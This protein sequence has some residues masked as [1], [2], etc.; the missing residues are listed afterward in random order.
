[1]T[2]VSAAS[3]LFLLLYDVGIE[4]GSVFRNR[5]FVV[6]VDGDLDNLAAA[7]LVCGVVELSNEGVCQRILSSN[8]LV[9]VELQKFL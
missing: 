4:F 3:S 2:V 9:G 5:V 6:V 8:S 1:M 7:G